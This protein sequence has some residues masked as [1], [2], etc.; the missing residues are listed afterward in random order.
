MRLSKTHT[1]THTQFTLSVNTEYVDTLMLVVRTTF[2][3]ILFTVASCIW[4]LYIAA[5]AS[6]RAVKA[7]WP[8][9]ATIVPAD[10]LDASQVILEATQETSGE[11]SAVTQETTGT[12]LFSPTL[13]TLQEMR[14]YLVSH[15]VPTA[16][17]FTKR[18]C[19]EWLGRS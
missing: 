2:K 10:T 9:Q 13:H 17:R 1:E 11:E 6:V 15:G 5:E 7:R 19:Q 18:Q 16:Y 8:R 4:L 3:I 14:S 12:F